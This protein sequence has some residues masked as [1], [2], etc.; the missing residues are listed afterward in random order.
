LTRIRYILAMRASTATLGDQKAGSRRLWTAFLVFALALT[1]ISI[2]L[3]HPSLSFEI[4]YYLVTSPNSSIDI[5]NTSRPNNSIDSQNKNASRLVI[6]QPHPHAG[7]RD[8]QGNWGYV[9]NV[10]AV[11][12]WMLHR[13]RNATGDS[14]NTTFLPI[15]DKLE[16]NR[17]CGAAPGTHETLLRRV[18][19]G[20]PD[21]TPTDSNSTNQTGSSNNRP[22][23]FRPSGRILCALYTH[24]GAHA[25]VTGIAETWGWR[26]DGFFAAS[27]ETV[28]D[29]DSLG[30]G[31]IDLAHAGNETRYVT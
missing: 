25:K 18:H 24:R 26:C 8:R 21:P 3:N 30:F 5:Q 16:E 6:V 27:D 28:D 1:N 13:I 11:R 17:V 7:A 9:A 15:N 20:A 4:N 23:V 14:A 31:A 12:R 2:S 29:P 19:L 10:K 22:S